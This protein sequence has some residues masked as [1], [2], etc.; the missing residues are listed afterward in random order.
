MVQLSLSTS[1][2]YEGEQN[3]LIEEQGTTSVGDIRDMT[4][5]SSQIP[6]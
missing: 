6:H 5:P 3:A 1:T 4:L 2:N